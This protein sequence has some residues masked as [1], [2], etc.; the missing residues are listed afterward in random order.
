[1]GYSPI[2]SEGF[3]LRPAATATLSDRIAFIQKVY[4]MTLTGLAVFF[5]VGGGLAGG[6]LL[7]IEPMLSIVVAMSKLHP[8]IYF[9]LFLGLSFGAQ[10]LAMVP[11]LNVA[12]FY[13]FA[14]ALGLLSTALIAVA[15]SV[16]GLAILAQALGL[17]VLTFGA[18]TAVVF[19]T[20][21]DFSF[22]GSF[23]MVGMILAI[24][25]TLALIVANMM[26][27]QVGMLSVALTIFTTLVFVGYI[28]YDTSNILHRYSTD[29]VVPAALA[30]LVDFVMLFRLILSLLLSRR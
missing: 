14:G 1:M 2:D 29:M 12:V 5:A 15:G 18:L 16:G 26:G 9:L 23:L 30:L 8:L 19:I 20:K 13:G 24:V 28:L 6:A 27:F 21:K 7:Q 4:L 17:T 3:A 22:L 10:R 11:G 25:S